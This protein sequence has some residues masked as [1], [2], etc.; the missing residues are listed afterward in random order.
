MIQGLKNE[1]TALSSSDV[2][3]NEDPELGPIQ[4]DCFFKFTKIP[5]IHL[6]QICFSRKI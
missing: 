1:K 3:N 6:N 5:N 4:L 2:K